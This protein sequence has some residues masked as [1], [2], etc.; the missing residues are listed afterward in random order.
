MS[1]NAHDVTMRPHGRFVSLLAI[2]MFCFA[3]A[4]QESTHAAVIDQINGDAVP[5]PN[6]FYTSGLDSIGWYYTPSFD[7]YLNGI[8][9]RFPWGG[10]ASPLTKSI[11]VQIQTDRPVLGGSVLAEASFDVDRLVGGDYGGTF[12]PILLHAGTTYFVDFLNVLDMGVNLGTWEYDS[13]N[14]PYPSGGATVNLGS[15]YTGA[16]SGF[17]V[18]NTSGFNFATNNAHVGGGEPILHFSGTAVPEPS[19]YV[20]LGMG[21]MTIALARWQRR[22]RFRERE[23][24]APSQTSSH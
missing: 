10:F 4:M 19:T 17:E 9:T 8:G 16:A 6:V 13:S 5:L 21:T 2:L 18:E 11:T 20:L 22:R 3:A 23:N 1:C 12:S 15:W 7:Y 14:V 24:V